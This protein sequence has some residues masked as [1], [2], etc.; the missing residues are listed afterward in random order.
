MA[1]RDAKASRT[2]LL[3]F[4]ASII[5]GIAAVVSI[6]LFSQTLTDNIQRQSKSL[7]GADFLINS[8][9]LPNERTQ[10]IIETLQPDAYEVNFVSMVAFPKNDGTKLVRVRGLQGDF[11]FYGTIETQP[12]DAANT[13]QVSGGALVD[14]TLMLQYKLE[15]GDSIKIGEITLPIA[16]AL[17]NIPGNSAVATS[18][19][20]MVIIPFRFIEATELLQFGSRKKYQYFYKQPNA[21]LAALEERLQP[22]LEAENANLQTHTSASSRLGRAYDNVGSFLN[23][24]AFIALLLGC[25]GIASSV[26][27]YIKEL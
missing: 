2:R 15:P 17:K 24:T 6:Q 7:M 27:I 19:A 14:A 12:V 16:G 10:A 9:Q 5:L 13:Y 20:P 25:V 4:M 18:V 23:L 26:N 8:D 21:D 22:L 1:W 11:P 3:L